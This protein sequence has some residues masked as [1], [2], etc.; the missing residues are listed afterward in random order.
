M[1]MYEIHQYRAGKWHLDSVY[2]N[3]EIALGEAE[4]VDSAGT[5]QAIRVVEVYDKTNPARNRVV[6]RGGD[7]TLKREAGKAEEPHISVGQIVLL[8]TVGVTALG[9]W[10]YLQLT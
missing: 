9:V 2:D 6:Y 5:V 8:V 1:I 7:V 4:R 10:I 3:E